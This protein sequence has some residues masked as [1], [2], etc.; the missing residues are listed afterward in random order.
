ME[1]WTPSE[2]REL[3]L[4]QLARDSGNWRLEIGK[5]DQKRQHRSHNLVKIT[6]ALVVEL[7]EFRNWLQDFLSM[8]VEEVSRLPNGYLVKMWDKDGLRV[9]LG[10]DGMELDD[11]VLRVSKHSPQMTGD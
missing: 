3:L 1:D 4:K 11:E 5:G 6:Q 7:K 10:L 8:E 2:E 9:A